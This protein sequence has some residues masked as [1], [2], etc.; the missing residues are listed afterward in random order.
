MNVPSDTQSLTELIASII[1][2]V[3][4][5]LDRNSFPQILVCTLS[6]LLNAYSASLLLL[7]FSY[8]FRGGMGVP[9]LLSCLLFDSF[10]CST[11]MKTMTKWYLHQIVILQRPSIMLDQLVGRY[12]PVYFFRVLTCSSIN[13]SF[14]LKNCS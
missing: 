11:R 6:L 12:N 13:T 10:F 7:S 2:R 1:Q 9:F 8:Q 3:G 5:D 4:N 14:T